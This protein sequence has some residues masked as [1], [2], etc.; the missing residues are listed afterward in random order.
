MEHPAEP[1]RDPRA[2]SSWQLPEL[3]FISQLPRVRKVTRAQCDFGC[4]YQ[5]PATFL[6]VQAPTSGQIIAQA[7]GDACAEGGT[8]PRW[9]LME[10]ELPNHGPKD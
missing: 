4:L 1:T 2:P 8:L 5:E 7:R 6:C 9:G 10:K 3:K